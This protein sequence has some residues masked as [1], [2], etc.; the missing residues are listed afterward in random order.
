MLRT[1]ASV[2][3]RSR[4]VRK[5]HRIPCFWLRTKCVEDRHRT[6]NCNRRSSSLGQAAGERTTNDSVFNGGLQRF[7]STGR[8]SRYRDSGTPED[9]QVRSNSTLCDG[10]S[11]MQGLGKA[12]SV[13]IFAR[14]HDVSGTGGGEFRP[15]CRHSSGLA[16]AKARAELH[17]DRRPHLVSGRICGFVGRI[18][19]REDKQCL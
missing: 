14:Q 18:A 13:E 19:D 5:S 6:T 12:F 1:E 7:A 9:Q 2:D 16:F 11:R 4:A 17:Q 3:V 8:R 10:Y 15:L